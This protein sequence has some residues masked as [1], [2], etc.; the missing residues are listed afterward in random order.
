MADLDTFETPFVAIDLDALGRNIARAQ[1]YCEEHGLDLRPHTKTHKQPAIARMQL[2]AGAV[3]ITCQKLG[4]AEVMADAGLDDILITY[5]LVGAAKEQRLAALAGRVH[6]AVAADSAVALEAAARA[7]RAAGREIGFLVE[8]DGGLGRLGV[9]DPEQAAELAQRADSTD[10]V[11]W[12]GLMTYP[13]SERTRPFMDAARE[14]LGR[15]GLEPRVVSGGGT[16][17][18]YRTHELGGVTE[19]RAGEYALGD[20]SH[21]ADGVVPLEDVAIAV[22]A[23]VVSRPAPERAI[24]D[25]GSKTLTSDPCAS[26]EPGFGLVRELPDAQLDALWEEHGRVDLS[27]SARRPEIGERVTIVPNH[28]CPAINLHDRVVLHR[29]GRDAE[30]APVPARGRVR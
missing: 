11:D 13:T 29:G 12:L 25:A 9:A 16:P 1:R 22:V 24:L 19:V 18:L 8:C 27:A 6:I 5:P 7:G 4:E 28:V 20:R 23:T 10:G 14:A 30:A 21:V 17:T 3:G 26:G 2:D 15:R